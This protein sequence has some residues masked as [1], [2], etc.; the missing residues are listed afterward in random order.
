M[1]NEISPDQLQLVAVHQTA[2]AEFFR[3][4]EAEFKNQWY[5]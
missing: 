5:F 2:F 4:R 3:N 1:S